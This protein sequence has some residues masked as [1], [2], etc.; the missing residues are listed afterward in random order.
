MLKTIQKCDKIFFIDK[1]KVVDNGK[2]KELIKKL[3]YLK[4]W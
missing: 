2:Y 1:G 4:I 3:T